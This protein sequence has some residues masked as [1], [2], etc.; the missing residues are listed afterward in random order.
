[1]RRVDAFIRFIR[2]VVLKPSLFRECDVDSKLHDA[3]TTYHATHFE[4]S[5]TVDLQLQPRTDLPD[6][7]MEGRFISHD[8]AGMLTLR[9]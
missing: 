2:H 5:K 9:P 8:F 4:G 3:F 7:I 6:P 1:M